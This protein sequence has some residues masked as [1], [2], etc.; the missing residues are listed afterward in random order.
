MAGERL[1]YRYYPPRKIQPTEA[2]LKAIQD[3]EAQETAGLIFSVGKTS[4]S[5]ELEQVMRG[6]M[7]RFGK[8]ED[9]MKRG[10]N[11][12]IHQPN[13]EIRGEAPD[14]SEIP[15]WSGAREDVPAL[16]FLKEHYGQW[17]SAFGAEQDAIYQ[18][19]IRKHD[20]KLLHG[21]VAQLRWEGQNRKIKEFVKPKSARTD[22]ELAGSLAHSRKGR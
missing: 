15:Q 12:P 9:T 6:V 11:P 8:I 14:L 10:G 21:V 5:E 4:Q 7:K 3:Q 17:L 18:D 20:P 22:R 19:Q 2:E 16:D 1:D 13:Q